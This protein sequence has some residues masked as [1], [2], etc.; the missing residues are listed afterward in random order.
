MSGSSGMPR[1]WHTDHP[2]RE[3]R[4]TAQ[5]PLFRCGGSM[6]DLKNQLLKAG[7][8]TEDQVEKVQKEEADEDED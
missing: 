5:I 2:L 3:S 6:L 1:P 8:V 7:L 4:E